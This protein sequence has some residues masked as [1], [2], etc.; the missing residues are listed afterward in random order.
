MSRQLDKGKLE[1]KKTKPSKQKTDIPEAAIGDK[2]ITNDG[3]STA[4]VKN[5]ENGQITISRQGMEDLKIGVTEWTTLRK[6][7]L[8]ITRFIP[9]SS[10]DSNNS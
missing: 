5:I 8:A 10:Q 9:V 6:I 4:V 7:N 1:M 3:K 2:F